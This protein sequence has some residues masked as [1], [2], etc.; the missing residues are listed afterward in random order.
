MVYARPGMPT[1]RSDVAQQIADTLIGGFDKH[2]WLFRE[3]S[4]LAKQRFEDADWAG[5]QQAVR[6]RIRFY[7]E[8]VRECVERLQLE[9]GAETPDDEAWQQAKLLYIGLLV[10][11]KRPELAETFF[12][13]VVT[14]ILNRTYRHNDFIFV[15]S[16]ISTEYIESDPPIY[17]S[18]YPEEGELEDTFA[19]MLRAAGWSRPFADL[20]RDVGYVMRA[21]L[22]H[23]GGQWPQREPNFQLQ[24]L[25]SAFY[26]NKAA[27][28]IGRILNG[29][30]EMPFLIPVLHDA[31]GRLFL[32]A[33]ILD[34]EEISILFSL[35]RSYFMAAQSSSTWR[36]SA[37]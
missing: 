35:S 12:N 19:E 13:S 14:R 26:R 4:A 25:S 30:D 6:E 37:S 18:Y 32:D 21:L 27:F 24:V 5:A 16:A 9:L 36:L 8:R 31:D 3:T 15:R 20:D 28:L 2:Y 7:D 34:P 29:H 22:E 33:V 11:H 23:L 1:G 17:W 10:D